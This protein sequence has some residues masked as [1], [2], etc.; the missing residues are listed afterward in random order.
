MQNIK[1][2]K[3]NK[4]HSHKAIFKVTPAKF[5]KNSISLPKKPESLQEEK[6][7]QINHKL[8]KSEERSLTTASSYYINTECK[9]GYEAAPYTR[10]IICS[11]SKAGINSQ[12]SKNEAGK[13]Q[14]RKS[15]SLN[16]PDTLRKING[17]S[18]ERKYSGIKSADKS[19]LY[20]H[21]CDQTLYRCSLIKSVSLST[22]NS[23]KQHQEVLK[24]ELSKSKL[25][26]S[27]FS[28]VKKNKN[29]LLTKR[30]NAKEIEK[31]L[32]IDSKFQ[33]STKRQMIKRYENQVNPIH[34]LK[35]NESLTKKVHQRK[36]P[37]EH[38]NISNKENSKILVQNSIPKSKQR[39]T[40]ES[41]VINLDLI[42]G[43]CSCIDPEQAETM[44]PQEE[45]CTLS[46]FR[47]FMTNTVE[48][49]ENLTIDFC[50]KTFLR[51]I[52]ILKRH[53][54]KFFDYTDI[55]YIGSRIVFKE[56]IKGVSNINFKIYKEK[57]SYLI[58]VRVILY[59]I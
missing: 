16:S 17:Q 52:S 7:N 54:M 55:I 32:I 47:S 12:I 11:I 15:A 53:V 25:H 8:R 35:F 37:N 36:I 29:A 45:I 13:T 26:P 6:S 39:D 49:E 51:K 33:A 10:Q 3:S 18:H 2:D 31:T 21:Y 46:S 27:V 5:V 14:F 1:N 20:K 58:E 9:V 38:I 48:M 50:K 28:L 40:F 44:K 57:L 34:N 56:Y 24:L 42:D 19:I 30:V 43:C 22:I 23:V 59:I 41:A 4:A